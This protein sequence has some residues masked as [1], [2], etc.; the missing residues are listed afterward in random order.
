M[1]QWRERVNVMAVGD[2]IS[3]V[4]Q[5]VA[6]PTDL[7]I[8]RVVKRKNLPLLRVRNGVNERRVSVVHEGV[9]GREGLAKEAVVNLHGRDGVTGL[10]VV[11]PLK[12][13]LNRSGRPG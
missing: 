11:N 8:V 3:H 10:E 12:P 9:H 2:S 13:W 7:F 6:A 5:F 1:A 4:Q